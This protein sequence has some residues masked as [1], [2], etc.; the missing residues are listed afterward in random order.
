[1]R[2]IIIS[3]ITET[4]ESIIPYGLNV[5]KH[6]QTRV[7]ILHY[8]DPKLVHGTYS[9]VSDSQS[10]TPGEKFS[11]EEILQREKE[12]T[13]A[14][15]DKLLSKEGSRLNFPLR[16]N[17]FTDIADPDSAIT[18][19]IEEHNNPLVIT[20]MNPSQSM[21]N[22]LEDLLALLQNSGVRVLILPA[23][24]KFVKPV[25]CCMVTDLVPVENPKLEKLFQWIEPLV[26]K[27]YTSAVTTTESNPYQKEQLEEWK[28]ALRPYKEKLHSDASEVVRID[29]SGI[30]IESICR[31]K[32]P[33]MVV[34]PFNGKSHFSRYVLA[35]NNLRNF[36]ERFGIPVLLY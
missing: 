21:V 18:E 14:K 26:E 1:M 4:E 5:G 30:A 11:H 34:F 19:K 29:E 8:F 17:T 32:S 13:R 36:L 3:D 12:I 31:H 9:P 24:K 20:G 23:G 27:I 2:T 25:K 7:D 22:G 35:E 16:I 33:D 10:I 15:I 6:T 28:Q